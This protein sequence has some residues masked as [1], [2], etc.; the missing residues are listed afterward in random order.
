MNPVFSSL[1][2]ALFSCFR[3]RASLQIEILALRHQLAV[4]QRSAN[5]RLRLGAADRVL[6]VWLARVWAEWRSGLVIVKPETVIAWQRKGFRLY[7]SWKSRT[8][9]S[10]RPGVSSEVR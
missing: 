6:W 10:G 1:L 7:C 5:K 9:Q 3:N 4:M 8:G 2:S